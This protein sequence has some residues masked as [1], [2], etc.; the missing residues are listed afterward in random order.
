MRFAVVSNVIEIKRIRLAVW[1]VDYL[2]RN[3]SA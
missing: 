2:I 1:K 3:R